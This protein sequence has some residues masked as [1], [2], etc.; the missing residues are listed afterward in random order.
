MKKLFATCVLL[1]AATFDSFADNWSKADINDI[2]GYDGSDDSPWKWLIIIGIVL[3]G[4][5]IKGIID[6]KKS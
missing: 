5:F 4:A 3:L 2:Y 1:A 6:A